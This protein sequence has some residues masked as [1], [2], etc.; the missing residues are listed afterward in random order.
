MPDTPGYA[1]TLWRWR[2]ERAPGS[3][4]TPP[5]SS[6]KHRDRDHQRLHVDHP[7]VSPHSSQEPEDHRSVHRRRA[8]CGAGAHRL[9]ARRHGPHAAPP[10]WHAPR[11]AVHALLTHWHFP[12]LTR[13]RVTVSDN[14]NN[15]L[16]KALSGIDASPELRIQFLARNQ[17]RTLHNGVARQLHTLIP[18]PAERAATLAQNRCVFGIPTFVTSLKTGDEHR[19]A[20]SPECVEP[21]R[22]D[23]KAV[24]HTA[25][26]PCFIYYLFLTK[27]N[28]GYIRHVSFVSPPG[29]FD[30]P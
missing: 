29:S 13:L 1:K 22:P 24:Q 26:S 21:S 2:R 16:R 17:A 23:Q 20:L 3:K 19:A 6:G 25:T 8:V 14:P 11:P 15:L 28:L 4:L 10:P 9:H 18:T 5:E 7:A 27:P 12:R 30:I